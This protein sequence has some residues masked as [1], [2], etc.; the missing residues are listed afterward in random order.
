[1]KTMRMMSKE[2]MKMT[3]QTGPSPKARSVPNRNEEDPES[4]RLGR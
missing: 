1:M 4:I 2:M 3:N